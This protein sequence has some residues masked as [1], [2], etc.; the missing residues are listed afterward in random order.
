MARVPIALAVGT[1]TFGAGLIS[2]VRLSTR[3]TVSMIK[4]DSAAAVLSRIERERQREA[5]KLN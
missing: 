2:L 1:V 4:G 3:L 5:G